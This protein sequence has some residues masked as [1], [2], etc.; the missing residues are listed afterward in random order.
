MTNPVSPTPI[1]AL[2]AAPQPSDTPAV[3]D[4][5][6]FA[7]LTAQTAMVGQMNTAAT[8]T[9]TNATAANERAV[10][11]GSSATAAADSAAAANL[12]ATRLATLD[13]LWLGASATDP[14][15]GKAGAALVAGNAY[16]NTATGALR[17]YSGSAWVQGVYANAG[18]ASLNGQTGTLVKSTLAGYGITNAMAKPVDLGSNVDLNLQLTPG[19]FRFGDTPTNA[20]V[21]ASWGLLQ[22]FSAGNSAWQAVMAD[23]V[24]PTSLYLRSGSSILSTP[25]WTPW[26]RVVTN[27]DDVIALAG[28][29]IDCAK[30][31]RFTETVGA[32]RTLSFT[33]IPTGA[34]ACVLEINH[35]GGTITLPAGSVLSN[36]SPLSLVAGK[37]HLLYFERAQLGT[38]GWYV[39]TLPNYTP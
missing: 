28:G 24:L 18:V 16:V 11:A 5:K 22:V 23:S 35:T 13:A 31:N 4:S 7:L 2:P 39:S 9:Y 29:A 8:Q 1:D 21:G 3:F 37:R 30:G 20:P 10:S 17:A 33:N 32:N 15:T 12:D 38:A 27:P 25:I 36:G 14:T 26:R 19:F 34:Y 6:A